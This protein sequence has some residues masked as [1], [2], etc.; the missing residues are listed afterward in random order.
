MKTSTV[1]NYLQNWYGIHQA[2]RVDGFVFVN[3][4]PTGVPY[5]QWINDLGG[6]GFFDII[7]SI[8]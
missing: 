5:Y 3:L 6:E 4:N 2:I 8:I 7:R 1:F